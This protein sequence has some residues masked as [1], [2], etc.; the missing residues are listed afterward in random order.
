VWPALSPFR[1]HEMAKAA[2]EMAVWDLWARR[3]GVPLYRL[4][5]GRGG[6]IQAGVSVGL[7]PDD[8]ALLDQV[9]A[10]VEAG[11]RRI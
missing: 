4:L 2:L 7:Q 3:S 6:T 11:F 8:A 10:E 1:G 5:G 9:A